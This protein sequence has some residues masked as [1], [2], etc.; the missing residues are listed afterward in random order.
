MGIVRPDGRIVYD[1][2]LKD[3]LKIGG[4]N[5]AALEIE[6]FLC[7]HPDIQIAQVIG[8]PDDHLFEVAAAF[9]ELAPGSTLTP[10]EVVDFCLGQIAS[11]KI[12]R[13]VRI[14][15]DWPMSTTKIQK[16]KLP[17]DFAA[18][19]KIDPKQRAKAS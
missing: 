14:V 8:V 12:P 4:E 7:A 18:S 13:Y 1:G 3:M 11:Y 15:A 17:R 5:V 19:E 10:D 2:R 9:V 16:F 6:T